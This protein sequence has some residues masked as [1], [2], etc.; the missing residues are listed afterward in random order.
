MVSL[1]KNK[2]IKKKNEKKRE[3]GCQLKGLGNRKSGRLIIWYVD[4]RYHH[5]IC[6]EISRYRL[7]MFLW[8]SRRKCQAYRIRCKMD[9][10]RT[11]VCSRDHQ[12]EAHQKRTGRY[13]QNSGVP[14]VYGQ[15]EEYKAVKNLNMQSSGNIEKETDVKVSLKKPRLFTTINYWRKVSD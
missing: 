2:K 5:V 6:E 14:I 8:G 3:E 11:S 15:L 1:I 12:R 7:K 4:T 9:C 10:I 13:Y